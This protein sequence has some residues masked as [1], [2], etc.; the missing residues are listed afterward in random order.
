MCEILQVAHLPFA[1]T[2]NNWSENKAITFVKKNIPTCFLQSLE[3]TIVFKNKNSYFGY[4]KGKEGG[5]NL[6]MILCVY[7]L[8]QAPMT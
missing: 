8:D 4:N 1:N 7:S 3:V 5:L 6:L 2:R